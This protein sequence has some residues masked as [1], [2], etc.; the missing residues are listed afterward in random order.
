MTYARALAVAALVAMTGCADDD[1]QCPQYDLAG[2]ADI[3]YRDPYSGQC[4]SFGNY[5]CD[6]PCGRPCP[7]LAPQ[8]DWGQCNV[9]REGLDEATCRATPSCRAIYEGNN[10]N[11]H[12]CW[13]VAQSGPIGTSCYNLDAQACSSHDDCIAIHADGTP[14]GPFMSC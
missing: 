7:G 4:Q 9:G 14:I 13:G 11:F 1:M 8:P 6:D 12:E 3:Q 10:T 5:D 2:F